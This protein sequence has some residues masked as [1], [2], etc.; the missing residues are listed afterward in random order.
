VVCTGGSSTKCGA[1]ALGPGANAKAGCEWVEAAEADGICTKT[2]NGAEAGA[3]AQAEWLLRCIAAAAAAG[4]GATA[5][6]GLGLG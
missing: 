4:A 5:S 1:A 3:E 2:V 6:A